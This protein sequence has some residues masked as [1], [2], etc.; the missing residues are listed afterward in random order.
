MSGVVLGH[1]IFAGR[2]FR[3]MNGKG[4]FSLGKY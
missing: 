3:V 4:V 2:T 1:A